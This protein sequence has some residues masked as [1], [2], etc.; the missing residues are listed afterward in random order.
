MFPRRLELPS[1][2]FFLFGPRGTGKTTWLRSVLP[3]EASHWFDL[4]LDSELVRLTRDPSRFTAEVEALKTGS[5]VVVDEVQKLPSLLDR[6]QDLIARH[7]P[8]HYRFALTGS[9]ARKLRRRD[10]NLLP[11]RAMRQWLDRRCRGTSRS[12]S[13]P[14]SAFGYPHGALARE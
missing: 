13:T 2:S 6:V 14:C 4:I 1:S 11:G 7:G 5:W 10:A 12:S 9:S 3:S 8:R